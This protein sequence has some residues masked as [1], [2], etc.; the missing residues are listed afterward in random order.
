MER[1]SIINATDSYLAEERFVEPNTPRQPHIYWPSEASATYNDQ[2]NIQRV[3]GKCLRAAFYSILGFEKSNPID[4]RGIRI[5]TLGKLVEQAEVNWAKEAGLWWGNNV[6][7]RN[8]TGNITISGEVDMF[9]RRPDRKI[10]GLEYKTGYG[11]LFQSEIFGNSRKFGY[12]KPEHLMQVMLYLDH[13]SMIDDFAI[14]Y[15]DRGDMQRAEHR[16]SL[17]PMSTEFGAE[18]DKEAV[19]TSFIRDRNNVVTEGRFTL[20]DIYRRYMELDSSIENA[21]VPARDYEVIWDSDIVEREYSIGNL[22][23]S[24]FEAWK[25]KGKPVGDWQCLYCSF[26]NVCNAS[27]RNHHSIKNIPEKFKPERMK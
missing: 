1:W 11:Y 3:L 7:F 24:K 8:Q 15:V 9:I 26:A 13:Y 14:V 16:V 23:K 2:Y 22:S 12:P 6:K 5:L 4:P 21:V 25:K 10:E 19:V 27:L 18:E 17:K 20:N